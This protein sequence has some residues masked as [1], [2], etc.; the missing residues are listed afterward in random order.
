MQNTKTI[1]IRV[2]DEIAARIKNES[3]KENRT[4]NNWF[5]NLLKIYFDKSKNKI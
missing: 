4:I 2:A 1:T 5:N 3:L